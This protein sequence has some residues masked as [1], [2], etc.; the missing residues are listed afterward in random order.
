M[1]GNFLVF[2][3]LWVLAIFI[4]FANLLAKTNTSSIF[5]LLLITTGV[6]FFMF[7]Y[8]LIF[9]LLWNAYSCSWT[10]SIRKFLLL[11]YKRLTCILMIKT[12]FLLQM[13]FPI[14][15]FFVILF[16]VILD[17]NNLLHFYIKQNHWSFLL[18]LKGHFLS[19]IRRLFVFIFF[20]LRVKH[21]INWFNV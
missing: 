6:H 3:P 9:L 8:L 17:L 11:I 19:K 2:L 14:C 1:W 20:Y 12:F 13:L 7:I 21:I 4:I 15:L 5:N 18:C 16:M 10:F